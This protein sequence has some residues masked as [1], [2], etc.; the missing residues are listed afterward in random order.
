MEILSCQCEGTCL[1]ARKILDSCAT[2][3]LLV[4]LLGCAINFPPRRLR[5]VD[6]FTTLLWR[7][8]R[9]GCGHGHRYYHCIIICI[10]LLVWKEYDTYCSSMGRSAPC[11]GGEGLC[12]QGTRVGPG[13]EGGRAHSGIWCCRDETNE[14]KL[15]EDINLGQH[16]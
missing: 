10:G 7:G 5:L 14:R 8:C 2:S 6:D 9:A 3:T 11:I 12:K 1:P 16:V 4:R 15:D 13:R